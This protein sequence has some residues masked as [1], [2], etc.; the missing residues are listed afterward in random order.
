MAVDLLWIST[1][2]SVLGA[3]LL[4][5]IVQAIVSVYFGPLS[6]VPGPKLAAATTWWK[7]YIEVVKQ[8]SWTDKLVELHSTYG[9]QEQLY[10]LLMDYTSRQSMKLMQSLRAGDVVRMAPNEACPRTI[11]VT[12]QHQGFN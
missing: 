4:T 1:A 6:H 9:I 12:H 10:P 2:A 3:W 7:A 5:R 11:V 8:V